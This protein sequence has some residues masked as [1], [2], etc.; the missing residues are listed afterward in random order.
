MHGDDFTST[1]G[2]REL[3]WLEQQLE[4]KYEL[5]KGGRMG[6]G[7]SDTKELTVLKRILR[8]TEAG[9]V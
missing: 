5:R 2:K 4:S 1:G 3:D 6:Q 9:Y 7:P 8:Y